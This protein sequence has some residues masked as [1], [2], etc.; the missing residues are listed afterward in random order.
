MSVIF[1][2]QQ[3]SQPRCIKRISTIQKAGFPIKVYGFDSGLYNDNLDKLPF[4]ITE[5]VKRDKTASKYKK[6]IFFIRNVRR[7]INENSQNDL[8]YLFGFEIGVISYFLKCKKFIYE[9]ADV[10]AARI[11]NSII[12]RFLLMLDRCVI[13]KSKLTVFT[14]QGFVKY[15]FGEIQPRNIILIPNKLNVYFKEED[16]LK[17]SKRIININHIKFGFVG[18]IRYPN[19]IIRFAKVIGRKF[20][21]HEFHF[22]GQLE[23]NNYIDNEINSFSNIYF[24]GA[25]KSPVD[26][27]SIY[28][29]I[30]INIVCYDISSDNVRIAEP[31]KLY[32]SIFF[33]TPIIVSKDTF[34]SERVKEYD[35]GESID[36]SS[37]DTISSFVESLKQEQIEHY[38]Q[39]C[40]VIPY[41]EIIDDSGEFIERIAKYVK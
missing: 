33:E 15:I 32:E 3:L 1:I 8:F 16:K 35:I 24:H 13:K 12:R 2:V 26:L 7:I 10:S 34:L 11:H 39:S 31:N 38:I 25:F 9:E 27:L 5:I 23:R 14:S 28:S 22:Y 30:D 41:R 19:T 29:A 21:H 18:L 37:D 36:A 40:K 6:I 17:V 20:P 4:R